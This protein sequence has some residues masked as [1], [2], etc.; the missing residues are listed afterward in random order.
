MD[1]LR[2]Q[3]GSTIG[4]MKNG[5]LNHRESQLV[6]G[7]TENEDE[8]MTYKENAS[9]TANE[10]KVTGE[11]PDESAYG[12]FTKVNGTAFEGFASKESYVGED[13][14]SERLN[15]SGNASEGGTTEKMLE[16][17]G[18]EFIAESH[19]VDASID[20]QCSEAKIPH[21]AH[22]APK[23]QALV[24]KGREATEVDQVNLFDDHEQNSEFHVH[25]GGLSSGVEGR[26]ATEVDQ[27]DLFNDHEQN[28]ESHVHQGGLSSGAEGR[29]ATEV[30]QVDLFDD[31]GLTVS[32]LVSIDCNEDRGNGPASLDKSF[33]EDKY[34]AKEKVVGGMMDK[35]INM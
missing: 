9:P 29:E 24:P 17:V 4:N 21:T 3:E 7:L 13:K 31:H 10:E 19:V 15:F 8:K 32:S 35:R 6:I 25:Q 30:D 28:S 23:Y 2:M 34:V 20:C 16:L 18:N 1:D 22:F 26:E 14:Q 11:G 12:E 27:V 33:G 5:K